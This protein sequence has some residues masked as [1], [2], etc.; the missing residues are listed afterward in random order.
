MNINRKI[1]FFLRFI[2]FTV[3][4]YSFIVYDLYPQDSTKFQPKQQTKLPVQLLQ[5]DINSILDNPDFANATIGVSVFN[6]ESG[7]FLYRRNDSKNFIPASTLKLLTTAAALEYLGAD[8]FYTTNLYLDGK[9]QSNNEFEGNIIFRGAGD[10]T[11]SAYFL[12]NP[13]KVIDFFVDRLDSLGIKSIKGNLITDNRY[14]DKNYYPTGWA[15][16]DIIYP[17]SAQVDALSFNDNKIDIIIQPSKKPYTLSIVNLVPPTNY[18]KI[19]NNVLT[20]IKSE[21]LIYPKK[22]FASNNIELFGSIQYDSLFKFQKKISVS[23]HNPSNFFLSFVKQSLDERNIRFKGALLNIDDVYPNFTYNQLKPICSFK[24]PPLSQII[25][26]INSQSHNLASEMLLK[27]IGKEVTGIGST[28]SG[29]ETVKRFISKIGIPPENIFI[30]DGSGL[31]RMNLISPKY[32]VELL[33]YMYRSKYKDIFI[34]SLAI[35]GKKGTLQKRMTK[36]LAE[37]NVFAKTGSLQSNSSICGY[38]RNKDNQLLAFAIMIM[39][40]TVPESLAQN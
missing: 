18:V 40:Y 32:L 10:P 15:I 25:S 39:N 16:D 20:E 24:S 11:F 12:E 35:S 27:T 22:D 4:F 30:S 23:I 26:V 13:L 21:S 36:S 33:A 7:E 28:E 29:I 5:E 37:N 17:F 19:I 6:L 14:F 31:S 38:V 9:I 1:K 34:N 8:F 3:L 2:F